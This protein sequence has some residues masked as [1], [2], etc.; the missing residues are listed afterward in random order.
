MLTW[1]PVLRRSLLTWLGSLACRAQLVSWL[2]GVFQV[3]ACAAEIPFVSLDT[4]V[5]LANANQGSPI[6]RRTFPTTS[7]LLCRQTN[8][9]VFVIGFQQCA[10]EP[11]NSVYLEQLHQS[12]RRWLDPPRRCSIHGDPRAPVQTACR[13]R[14]KARLDGV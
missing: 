9:L 10:G 14:W 5:R 12:P 4:L 13:L 3:I 8:Q 2:H 1:L 6:C 7:H 11:N